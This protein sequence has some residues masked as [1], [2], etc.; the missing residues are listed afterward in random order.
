M[1]VQIKISKRDKF[2]DQ[3]T[4]LAL[5]DDY[6][7]DSYSGRRT[8]SN[9]TRIT[10]GT[11]VNYG[12]LKK[13]LTEFC[14]HSTFELKLFIVNNLTQK[15]K[16]R[17]SRFYKKFYASFTAYMYDK[18]KYFD[19]YVGLMIKCLKSFFNYLEEDRNVSV[20]SFHRSFFVPVE[21]IQIVTLSQDQFRF[22]LLDEEFNALVRE[23]D[24]E[25]IRD[26]FVFGCTVALR[27]SDLLSLTSKNLIIQGDRYYLSVK[28]KKTATHTSIKLPEYATDIIKKYKSRKSNLLPGISSAWFNTRLKEFARLMP[29]DFEMVKTR[30]RRGKQV[31]VYKDPAKR[32]H[33]KLSDHISTHTMRR[34]AITNMLCLGMPE[35]LVRKISGHAANSHEFFRYVRLSQSFIDLETD[36]VFGKIMEPI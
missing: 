10:D 25:T 11:I 16:E 12:Y 3:E 30:E 9:G 21:N 2:L 32:I 5:L 23:N 27:I 31:V 7:N 35:H 24:L 33:Y 26:I 18:K 34:T 29:D 22:I 6:I 19:N 14:E 36:K 15:E 20:G 1:A 28:S 8:K 13:N 17:A 4:F